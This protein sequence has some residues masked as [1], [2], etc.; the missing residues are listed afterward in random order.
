MKTLLIL[1][2]ILAALILSTGCT[3]AETRVFLYAS[4]DDRAEF[5]HTFATEP[6][7]NGVTLDT[8]LGDE[9]RMHYEGNV[10]KQ[11]SIPVPPRYV[12]YIVTTGT[13]GIST[14]RA[15]RCRMQFVKPAR[16]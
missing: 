15:T 10:F 12:G 3:K 11:S 7:C 16:Y 4:N 6:A 13:A 9:P 1:T 8:T 14:S 2:T 5:V